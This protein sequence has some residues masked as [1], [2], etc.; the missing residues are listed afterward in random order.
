MRILC[1]LAVLLLLG[2]CGSNAQVA[3]LRADPMGDWSGP[4]LRQTR[5]SVTEPGTTLSKPR[6][7][8]IL[9]ILEVDDRTDVASALADV[10]AA[11]EDA[12]WSV[13]FERDGGAFTAEKPFTVDGEELRGTL[14]AGRQDTG[15]HP[16]AAEIF[17]ALQAY[18]A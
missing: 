13:T 7:A 6:Y 16:A 14:T 11:A 15:G 1:L 8:R 2:G 10:R 18:P 4:G 5:E 12:G 17:L 9:R 3:A